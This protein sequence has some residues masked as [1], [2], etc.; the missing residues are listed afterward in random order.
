M[1]DAQSGS[2]ELY[3]QK[4]FIKKSQKIVPIKTDNIFY[5]KSKGNYLEIHLEDGNHLVR[6]SLKDILN[7]LDPTL[8]FQIHRSFIVNLNKIKFIESLKQTGDYEVQLINNKK[9]R[10][11]RRYKKILDVFSI[12]D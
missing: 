4:I 11:S 8:F 5:I 12:S 9:L 1:E 7:K 2:S 10:L 3:L 6:G